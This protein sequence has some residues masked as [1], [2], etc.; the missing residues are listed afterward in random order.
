MQP[1]S[2]AVLALL[3]EI[4]NCKDC[5]IR[6]AKTPVVYGTAD[7]KIFVVSE[8]PPEDA[9]ISDLGKEWSKHFDLSGPSGGAARGFC[10]WLGIEKGPYDC[11]CWIQRANCW[12]GKR[13]GPISFHCSKEYIPRAIEVVKPKVIVTLG[14]PAARWFLE[15]GNLSEVVGNEFAYSAG[16]F[17]CPVIPL[18]HPSGRNRSLKNQ[19]AAMRDRVRELAGLP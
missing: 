10:R 15:F 19:P 16:S 14:R 7:S 6:P 17:A 13:Y 5:D 9:W 12:A 4:R 2:S 11:L 18:Y 8:G 1:K 3:E